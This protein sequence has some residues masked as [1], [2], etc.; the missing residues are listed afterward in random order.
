M[1]PSTAFPTRSP[2]LYLRSKRQAVIPLGGRSSR[3]TLVGDLAVAPPVQP[4]FNLVE[5]SWP[6]SPIPVRRLIGASGAGLSTYM[7]PVSYRMRFT[8]V[9]KNSS[10]QTLF[11]DMGPGFTTINWSSLQ[12][13]PSLSNQPGGTITR[14]YIEGAPALSGQQPVG[15]SGWQEYI[16]H[17]GVVQPAA[18]TALGNARFVRLRFEFEANTT[19][20]MS[21]ALEGFLLGGA[22]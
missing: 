3:P 19:S 4:S 7:D 13:M 15:G 6:T 5:G 17:F 11:H 21:P 12:L 1:A 2:L 10:A 14:V 20:N 16:D 8:F 9:P 22:Y 18:L